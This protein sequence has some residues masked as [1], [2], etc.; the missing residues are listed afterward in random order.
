MFHVNLHKV[1][2]NSNGNWSEKLFILENKRYLIH[3]RDNWIKRNVQMESS[4]ASEDEKAKRVI[5]QNVFVH[6]VGRGND[7]T[8]E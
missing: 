8:S 3:I 7:V 4:N 2:L 1:E 6:M 5:D